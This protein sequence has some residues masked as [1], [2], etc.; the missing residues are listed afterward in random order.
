VR[1]AADGSHVVK[2]LRTDESGFGLV[3][4]T[5]SMVL[6]SISLLALVAAFSSG[7]VTLKRAARVATATSLGERQM[8][9]YRGLKYD[10][11]GLQSG[12]VA[13]ADPVWTASRPT[14]TGY[15]VDTI[16]CTDATKPECRPTQTLDGPDGR[17]YRI[18]SYVM[19]VPLS[20]THT[21]KLVRVMVRDAETS[22]GVL[23]ELQS[24][25]DQSTGL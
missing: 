17:S 21:Y 20:A 11:I 23:A 5:F 19:T 1:G 24:T 6:L 9:L 4:L 7:A 8:E 12:L 16:S 2:R 22:T 3:E 15:A 10:A 14:G 18:D 13:G 25:F